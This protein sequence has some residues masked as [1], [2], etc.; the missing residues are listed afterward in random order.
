MD[1]L[2]KYNDIQQ[3]IYDYFDFDLNDQFYP[4]EDCCE[5][6]WKIDNKQ[7]EVL[8]A[9]DKIELTEY[10]TCGYDSQVILNRII[11]RKEKYTMVLIDTDGNENV[12]LQIFDN[13]KEVK[14]L[15]NDDEILDPVFEIQDKIF[16]HFERYDL[17]LTDCRKYFWKL[18]DENGVYYGESRSD[19]LF[20]D[21]DWAVM[22]HQNLYVDEK[23][24]IGI[25]ETDGIK[26]LLVFHNF[27]QVK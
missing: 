14:D 10:G 13:S 27:R 11:Y 20:E 16:D 22:D 2:T 23:Y 19:L 4:I 12:Y 3:Q 17:V 24:T 9:K 18:D 6:F 21:S 7:Y 8:Y 15:K 1:L 26:M 25:S 5:Y